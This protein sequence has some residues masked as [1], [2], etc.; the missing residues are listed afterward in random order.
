[1]ISTNLFRD[2]QTLIGSQVRLEPLTS[3]HFA[4]VWAMLSD[5]EAIR[6]T[7]SQAEFSEPAIRTWLATRPRQ[8]DR[9]DWAIMRRDE[10]TFLG[11]VVLNDLDPANASMNFRIV[12]GSERGR[13]HGTEATNLVLDHGFA[14][15]LHRIHLEVFDFNPR[16]QRVY[17]KC[18]FQREGLHRDALYQN[19]KWH[20]AISMAVLSTDP[21]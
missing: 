12:L 15:G 11:E 13:G 5:P 16:A 19:G 2:Q 9:A 7:G 14:V 18:G 4:G 21:R 8:F 3:K 10:D 6:L 17:E 20:H 1:V